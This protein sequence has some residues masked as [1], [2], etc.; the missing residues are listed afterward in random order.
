MTFSLS[1]ILF[2][3]PII[4]FFKLLY[5]SSL[6]IISFINAKSDFIS[7]KKSEFICLLYT[8]LIIVLFPNIL[9][10]F[11]EVDFLT[12]PSLIVG[13]ISPVTLL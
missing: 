4:L 7:Y 11:I 2:P 9:S 3:K 6:R 10:I 1:L 13:S 12:K 8:S 5:S